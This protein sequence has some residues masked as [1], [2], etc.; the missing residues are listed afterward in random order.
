MNTQV[1]SLRALFVSVGAIQLATAALGTLVPLQIAAIG[2]TQGAAS[3]VAAAYSLGFMIGCFYITKPLARIGHIRAF[4]AA[5]AVCT[6]FT[7]FLSSTQEPVAMV[8]VRFT[9]GLATAGLYAIGDAWINDTAGPKNRGRILAVYA[10]VLGIVSVLSQVFVIRRSGELSEAFVF[11]SMF[12][13]I[14]IIVLATTRTNP[15]N[16]GG[17]ANVR[18]REVFGE[19][20]TAFVGVFVNGLIVTVMLT[21]VP[22]RASVLGLDPS[23]IAIGIGLAY[24]GRIFFQFP[25]GRAS[26]QMDRRIIVAVVA[27]LTAAILFLFV[28]LGKGD[29]AAA[30]GSYGVGWQLFGF[31]LV[32]LMGGMLLPTYSLLVAHGMDRTVPV[33]VPSAAV[34]LLF[35]W[36]LGGV[37][38]PI[39]A[40][41]VSQL[42]GDGNLFLMCFVIAFAFSL[43]VVWRM[44]R[45][46]RVPRAA[47]VTHV[48]GT[49]TSVE[50]KPEQKRKQTTD[51]TLGAKEEG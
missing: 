12:Y 51:P 36:T 34:T 19:S 15:V 28:V 25:L 48:P 1:L 27:G 39:L 29:A 24:A 32:F 6:L 5:A 40:A 44:Q 43:F 30:K 20:P 31:A 10:T 41:I 33:Y 9:T 22:F 21:V 4:T 35:V 3:I 26:D 23:T 16:S 14:A 46:D 13:C 45:R 17:K 38:G 42:L 49:A 50:M 11:V 18:L 37:T 8:M 47:Q 7:L 2:G